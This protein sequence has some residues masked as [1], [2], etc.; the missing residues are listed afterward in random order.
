VLENLL[1][2]HLGLV[3]ALV[4]ITGGGL[5]DNPPRILPEGTAARVHLGSWSVPPL[6]QLVRDASGLDADELHRTLNM[7]IGMVLVVAATDVAAVQAEINEDSWVIGEIVEGNRTV[8][9]Y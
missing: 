2:N 7:G 3:K 1:D 6:F 9:L 8:T 4:H 5:L